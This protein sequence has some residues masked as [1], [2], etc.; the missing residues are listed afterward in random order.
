MRTPITDGAH[1]EPWVFR[2][3]DVRS[4]WENEHYNRPGGAESVTATDWIPES[5]PIWFVE[6]GCPA[7]DKGANAPN[8]FIDAKSSES[9]APHFSNGE[10]DDLIQRRA[11]EAYLTHFDG[12]QVLEEAFL[13][14]WDARP[15]PA[16]PSRSD[17]WSDAASWRRGHW[18][19]GRAG[20]SELAQ[21]VTALCARAGVDGVDAG[22]LNGAVGGCVIDSPASTRD[23]LEPLMQAY[24]FIA[25]EREGAIVFTHRSDMPLASIDLDDVVEPGAAASYITRIDSAETPTEARVQFMDADQDYR[26]A[27]VSAR[28]RD[29][30]E[31]GVATLAAPLVLDVGQAEAL[32]RRALAE[33]RAGAET[34][35]IAI[36]PGDLAV[37]PGDVITLGADAYEI[38]RVEEAEA[39]SLSLRRAADVAPARLHVGEGNAGG[40]PVFAPTP[41]LLT[42]DLPP[43]PNAENDERPLVALFAD[44]WLGPHEL[45]AG[46]SATLATRRAEI[47]DPAIVGELL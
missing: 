2:A 20:L 34:V 29:A 32:A 44:P 38:V 43:L 12:D 39:R 26:I 37:E 30:A 8:L 42:L 14:C 13:W 19:N 24:D 7:I 3:K 18:L 31:G 1:A 47:A 46:S 41:D 15:H 45:H 23:A 4:W 22:A 16:F 10:R 6:L 11:L 28:R 5:K 36:A 17:V 33:A 25:V 9:A 40:A 21:V 27:S 35:E